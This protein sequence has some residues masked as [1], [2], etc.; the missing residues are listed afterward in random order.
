MKLSAL[1]RTQRIASVLAGEGMLGRVVDGLGRPIDGETK[2]PIRP[3]TYYPVF[4]QP[5]NPLE[6]RVIS[7]P[8]SLLLKSKIYER[9]PAVHTPPR[10][11]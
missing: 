2:G 6:R 7:Q 4:A 3:E 1:R 9:R 8:I 11:P 5:P 10:Q